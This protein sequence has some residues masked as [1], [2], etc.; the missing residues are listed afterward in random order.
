VTN[1]NVPSLDLPAY[2]REVG[3]RAR[4][5]SRIWRAH[6]RGK[7]CGARAIALAIVREEKRPGSQCKTSPLRAPRA[8]MRRSS[9]GWRWTHRASSLARVMREIATLA[10][11]RRDNPNRPSGIRSGTCAF[12]SASSRIAA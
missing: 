8:A 10:D 12:R 6:Y 4:A 9:I 2:M 5:A 3:E 1:L 11:R 7:K